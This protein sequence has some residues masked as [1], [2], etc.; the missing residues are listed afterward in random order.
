MQTIKDIYYSVFSVFFRASSSDW[1]ESMNCWRGVLGVTLVEW[2]LIM[3]FNIWFQYFTQV[4][5]LFQVGKIGFNVLLVLSFCLNYYILVTRGTGVE[6]QHGLSA[7]NAAQR[8]RSV[9]TGS[10]FTGVAIGLLL[11]SFYLAKPH[12]GH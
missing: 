3:L 11:F 4:N 9:I 7:L 5:L 1:S 12:F 2:A 10:V 8:R 6:F